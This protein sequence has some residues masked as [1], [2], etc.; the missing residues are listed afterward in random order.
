MLSEDRVDPTRAPQSGETGRSGEEVG[1]GLLVLLHR[2]DPVERDLVDIG[3]ARVGVGVAVDKSGQD[4]LALQID[5]FGV[6]T[7]PLLGLGSAAH[8]DD[9]VAPDGYRLGDRAFSSTV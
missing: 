5:D 6:V 4:E 3:D 8:E 9:A 2:A 1:D 7:D